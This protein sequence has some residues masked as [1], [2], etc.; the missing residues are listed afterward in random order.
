M[1][2]V[3]TNGSAMAYAR[4]A[5]LGVLPGS[6]QW[7]Q[8]EP[9]QFSQFG[10]T[11]SKEARSPISKARAR[12]K[13]V[14]VD[15]DSGVEFEADLTLSHLTDFIEAFCFSQAIGPEVYPV[16][17]VT[18]TGYT[19]AALSAG[20]AGH[21]LYGAAAATTLVVGRGFK[22]FANNGIRPLTLAGANG[23]T[24]V[25]AGGLQVEAVDADQLAEV[26]IAGVRGAAGD[27]KID[28]QGNL[29]SAA[30]N[31]TT[32]GLAVGQIIHIGGIE[33]ANQ[34]FNGANYGFARVRVI[35]ANKLTLDKRSQPF[36]TDDGTSTGAGGANLRIDLLFGQFVRNVDVDHTDFREY[37]HQFELSSPGLMP[38]NATG[39][40]YAL[41]NYADTLS[42]NI[43]LSG[44]ATMTL[45]FA[46]TDTTKPSAVRALNAATAKEPSMVEA[47]GTASDIARLRSQEADEAGLTT[48]FKSTTFTLSNN[49]AGE[50]VIGKLGP[51]YMT[52]GDIE[53]DV[54]SQV[55]FTSPRMVD[56]VRDNLTIGMDWVLRNGDGGV[57]F[58]LPT[59]TFDGGG[60][61]YPENQS[62]LMSTTFMAHQEKALD[63]SLGVS[64]FPALPDE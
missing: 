29:T 62:V 5:T 24:E 33:A 58:D 56:A 32:L 40:E 31:F 10:T 53:V 41:G 3:L 28:A 13:G 19:V 8:L 39:F 21:L 37:S 20:Q 60:R 11:I 14:T 27:L 54:E 7:R 18:A 49:V 44:K 61:E 43:P 38:G 48:D 57:A 35:E 23:A 47:F 45:G 42:I 50:K 55:I 12:R 52:A 17:S 6:P 46:G 1:G 4:E 63:F 64:F 9:N 30:L 51:K 36:A 2:R 26:A 22:L 34:F 59:G 15:L 16:T 25:K